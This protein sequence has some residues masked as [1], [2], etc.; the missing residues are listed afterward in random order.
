MKTNRLKSPKT[1]FIFWTALVLVLLVF[2]AVGPLFLS[3]DPLKVN[4]AQVNLPP[5]G[6]YPLGT[7]YIGRC[8]MS[9]LIE[10]AARSIYSA[11][12]VVGVTFV[13]GTVIGTLSGF[14]GG[15][16]DGLLMR[17]VDC[18]QAF[19]SLVFTI[20]IA[21]MLGPG[22]VNCV[23]AL[24]VIGWTGYARLA[25]SQVLSLK[26][27][28]FVSA[29]RISGSSTRKILVRTILP[30]C[31]SPLVVSASMHIGGTILSFAGLSFLGLGSAPPFPEWGT[32]LND[33]R[34]RLQIAP[35][36][37]LFPGLAILSVVMVMGMFGDS[38]NKVLISSKNNEV[39]S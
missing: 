22:T 13:I 24:S 7:D 34:Q 1:Q 11:L 3:H 30:N 14:W 37:A 5:S 4:L 20:A 33:G 2:A 39:Q 9:R 6:E 36:A 27:R 28:T 32:M 35:W 29:A 25:R 31:L 21:G 17:V 16:L 12:I 8:I 23:I 15:R 19:P 10:G 26:E 18:F 38:L